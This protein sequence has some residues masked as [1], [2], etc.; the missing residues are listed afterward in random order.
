MNVWSCA[1][2]TSEFLTFET[3]YKIIY[4]WLVMIDKIYK[5][6]VGE[7]NLCDI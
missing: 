2:V 3:H 1:I 6:D 4:E 7:R 5:D